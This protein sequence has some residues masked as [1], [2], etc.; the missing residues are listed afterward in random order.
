MTRINIVSVPVSNQ[1][2]AKEFYLKMG[3]E[4]VTEQPMGNGQTW[5]Q[6]RFPG[7][8]AD[9]TLVTWFTKMPAGSLHGTTILTD[10]IEA[11]TRQLNEKGIATTPIDP[12][13]WGKF[14]MVSDPDGNMWVLH[15]M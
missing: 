8:G 1:Q 5:L 4:V 2:A 11:E 14:S 13:P 9:I 6:M 15:Q 3:L 12:Q 7:G 10:D